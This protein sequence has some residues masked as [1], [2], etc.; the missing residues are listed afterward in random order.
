MPG[1][2][3]CIAVF[4]RAPHGGLQENVKATALNLVRDGH[5]VAVFCP[6]GP[7]QAILRGHDVEVF[8]LAELEGVQDG[9]DIV[10][11][12]PGESR[13]LGY[14]AAARLKVPFFVTYH[15]RWIDRVASYHRDCHKILVVSPAVRDAVLAAAPSSGE[16]I[17]VVPNAV[18]LGKVRSASA[19]C[20]PLRAGR[21]RIAV[22][23]RFD[24]DKAP[25][26]RLLTKLWE[27]QEVCNA[28]HISW[29]IAGAGTELEEMKRACERSFGGTAPVCFHGWLHEPALS[30]LVDSADVA[31]APGRSALE[32]MARGKPV[33]AT[34]SAGCF[35]LVTED[36]FESAAYCNFG[37]Y[38]LSAEAIPGAVFDEL[39]ALANNVPMRAELGDRSSAFVRSRFDLK[40]H[41]RR[42]EELYIKAAGEAFP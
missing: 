42:L 17:V 3:V 34:G 33:V 14:R 27:R 39:D 29:D 30:E 38:G 10:H 4:F 24:A 22:A 18:D 1:L 37:G 16:R 12:H 25:L 40:A 32:A 21:L 5:D 36:R 7:F 28:H 23:S 8:D 2:K 15:G 13:V 35:G 11:A 41:H 20:V 26:I 31:I 6:A 19:P 9:F